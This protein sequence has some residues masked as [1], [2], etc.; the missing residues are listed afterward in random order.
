M[1]QFMPDNTTP[2]FPM[3]KKYARPGTDRNNGK[4]GGD[5]PFLPFCVS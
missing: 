1:P 2:A 5:P 3:S 4:N